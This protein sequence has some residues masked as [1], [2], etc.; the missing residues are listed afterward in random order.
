MERKRL[1]RSSTDK[2]IGGVCGGFAEYF[3]VDPTII[4][5]LW[6]IFACFGGSGLLVYIAALIIIP[7]DPFQKVEKENTDQPNDTRKRTNSGITFLISIIFITI[8]TLIL[9]RNLG[10]YYF[11]FWHL[12]WDVIFAI[13]LIVAGIFLIFHNSLSSS[14]GYRKEQEI[15]SEP[16]EKGSQSNIFHRS[17]TDK[18]IF[19]VC[20]GI[21]K[22]F[23]V[24][25]SFI[26]ILW[27][28]F[29][30]ASAGLAIILYLV[31]AI[32]LP[33]DKLASN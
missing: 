21:A 13:L 24:D 26:R 6:V 33:T 9:L 10:F 14:T 5:I 12:H 22:Y 27:V 23:D 16:T 7:T 18:K 25:P 32:I 31:L 4:R 28:L 3:N 30:L 11:H 15:G 8:G 20:G 1:Y 17:I 19:G 2:I 29:G